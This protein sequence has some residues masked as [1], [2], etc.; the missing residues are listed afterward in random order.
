ML[1]SI[2]AKYCRDKSRLNFE[3]VVG[4]FEL[5]HLKPNFPFMYVL[6]TSENFYFFDIF[7]GYETG[8]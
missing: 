5:T 7:R 8:T 4:K 2:E 1:K 6:K 3:K